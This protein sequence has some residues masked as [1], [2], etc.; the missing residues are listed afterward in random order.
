MTN[1]D[2]QKYLNETVPLPKPNYHEAASA[3]INERKKLVKE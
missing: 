1:E 3:A 2:G